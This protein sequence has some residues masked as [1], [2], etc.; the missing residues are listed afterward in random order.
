MSVFS[1]QN[2]DVQSIYSI[3]S[4]QWLVDITVQQIVR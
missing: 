4:I 2:S 3:D 1:D